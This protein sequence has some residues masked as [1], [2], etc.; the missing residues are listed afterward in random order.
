MTYDPTRDL[1]AFLEARLAEEE[2]SAR[3]AIE[4]N[5]WFDE[6]S[7]AWLEENLDPF[8]VSE[9]STSPTARFIVD[10]SPARVLARIES[11]RKVI[12]NFRRHVGG[13]SG[14]GASAYAVQVLARTYDWHPDFNPRWP[15]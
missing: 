9:P 11:Y 12:E 2:A 5:D 6:E 3:A 14:Y 8:Y 15:G 10:Q 1:T 7:L 13:Q 4:E